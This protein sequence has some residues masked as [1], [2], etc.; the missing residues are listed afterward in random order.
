M[1][2][3]KMISGVLVISTLGMLVSCDPDVYEVD[4]ITDATDV[5]TIFEWDDGVLYADEEYKR[6]G[7]S[8]TVVHVNMVNITIRISKS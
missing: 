2:L 1:N 4:R 3:K 7:I 5:G 8:I 6:A